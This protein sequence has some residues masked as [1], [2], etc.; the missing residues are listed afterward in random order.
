MEEQA[1]R[2]MT[3]KSYTGMMGTDKL[4]L[5]K[6]DVSDPPPRLLDEYIMKNRIW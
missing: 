1:M 4:V 2:R 3:P 5:S 6:K